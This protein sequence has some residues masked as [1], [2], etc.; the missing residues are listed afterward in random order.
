[1]LGIITIPTLQMRE[2]RTKEIKYLA[3]GNTATEKWQNWRLNQGLS[4]FRV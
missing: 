4:A 2:I 1:M 3:Q